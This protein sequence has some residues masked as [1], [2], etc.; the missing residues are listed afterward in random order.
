M[1]RQIWLERALIFRQISNA[2]DNAPLANERSPAELKYN[3]IPVA[4]PDLEGFLANGG[5]IDLVSPDKGLI[6]S[7]IMW[8]SDASLATNSHSQWIEIKN[9][10]AANITTGDGHEQVDI[11]R[12][13]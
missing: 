12:S 8:G 9:T 13:E 6:I 2:D 4:L 3:A 7:E 5:T 10:T 1:L 11:L